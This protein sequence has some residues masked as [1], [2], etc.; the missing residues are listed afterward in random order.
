[1][2]HRLPKRHYLVNHRYQLGQSLIIILSHSVVALCVAIAVSWYYLFLFD[3]RMFCDHNGSFFFY[4]LVAVA[5]VLCGVLVWSI[6]HS[7]HVAGM[8]L[9]IDLLL[10]DAARGKYPQQPILFRQ[11]DHFRWLSASLN[12]VL[13]RM[14]DSDQHLRNV[15][16]KL[17][18]I[19][20]H[21]AN[22]DHNLQWLA[23]DLR[24]LQQEIN[25]YLDTS[26]EDKNTPEA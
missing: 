8:F 3:Q 18:P 6:R 24:K 7:H 21:I 2:K 19:V 23:K 25:R 15:C 14:R 12:P 16:D 1:M 26:D 4:V 11:S 22:N 17:D 9:K 13:K 5:T 10:K 20:G